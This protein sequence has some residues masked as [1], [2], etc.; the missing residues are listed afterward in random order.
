MDDEDFVGWMSDELAGLAGVSAVALGGSCA[1]GT[2]RDDSDWDFA[3]YYRHGFNPDSLRATRWPGEVSDIGGWGVG[4]VMN[5]GAW[6]TID[7]RCV[8]VHYRDLGEV[9]HWCDEADHGRF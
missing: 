2:N 5:G 8:D 7:G 1:L 4:G 3:V 9:E 6:L